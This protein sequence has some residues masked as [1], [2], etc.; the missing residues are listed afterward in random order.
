METKKEYLYKTLNNSNEKNIFKEFEDP[1]YNFLDNLYHNEFL[2]LEIKM[3]DAKRF[4]SFKES[5]D[6]LNELY[7]TLID[8]QKYLNDDLGIDPKLFTYLG[9]HFYQV[10]YEKL[11]LSFNF[12]IKMDKMDLGKTP[13]LGRII[14][15]FKENYPQN[16]FIM[17]LSSQ[18]RNSIAH[19]SYYFEG[20]IIYLCNDFF[21]ECPKY[22]EYEDFEK[23]LK[24]LNII[25]ELFIAT[26]LDDFNSKY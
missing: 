16:K 7:N 22:F 18:N 11:K 4:L 19:Y 10:F 21:D 3:E 6:A 2:N 13:Q 20:S 24:K 14:R 9:A 25:V 12:F 15:K 5:L 1:I 17:E 8:N 23:E 26:F